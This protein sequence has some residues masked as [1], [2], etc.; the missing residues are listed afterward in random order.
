MELTDE[1]KGLIIEA[2]QAYTMTVR[3]NN[4]EKTE[5]VWDLLEEID[6]LINLIA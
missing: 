5:D 1:Q 2:L 3:R 4:P 6:E